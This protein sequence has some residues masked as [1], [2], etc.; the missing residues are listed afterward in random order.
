MTFY[1]ERTMKTLATA[2][3]LA[4]FA[5]PAAAQSIQV[6]LSPSCGCCKSWVKHLE[7]AGFSPKVVE[8][9]DMAAS[10]RLVGVPDRVQSCHTAIIEGYFIEGHVPA[11]DI[12]KLLQDKPAAIG[13]AVPDM[14]VGSPGMEVEGVTPDRYETLLV[15]ADGETTVFAKH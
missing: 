12:R 14:P 3:T 7:Q 4:L 9:K 11:P 6:H 1:L 5:A 2:L 13:L 10:K 8:S 15:G